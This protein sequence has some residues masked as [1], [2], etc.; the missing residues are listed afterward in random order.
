[1]SIGGLAVV[2]GDSVGSLS[3]EGTCVETVSVGAV[4]DE[5]VASYAA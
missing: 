2:N 4:M 1:M 5:D 3:S